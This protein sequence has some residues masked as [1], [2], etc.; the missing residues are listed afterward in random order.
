MEFQSWKESGKGRHREE[1]AKPGCPGGGGR[2]PLGA[3]APPLQWLPWPLSPCPAITPPLLPT[4]R[5]AQGRSR[6][7]VFSGQLLSKQKRGLGA[8]G[9][10]SRRSPSEKPPHP[11]FPCIQCHTC[12]VELE[13]LE[14]KQEYHDQQES[15][16]GKQLEITGAPARGGPGQ[17]PGGGSGGPR[18]R[19][20]SSWILASPEFGP[21]SRSP[22]F[23]LL[24]G[25]SQARAAV[26]RG[27]WF[28]SCNV[29]GLLG[30]LSVSLGAGVLPP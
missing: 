22:G 1:E 18:Q 23:P 21:L 28:L 2:S 9:S 15:W 30:R 20:C 13:G 24:L 12:L 17:L 19:G 14:I 11:T 25:S 29:L 7:R 10:G 27:S 3:E 6:S 26:A 5:W 8:D 4:G 16:T